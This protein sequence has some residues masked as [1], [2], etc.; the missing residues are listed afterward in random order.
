MSYTEVPIKSLK[1]ILVLQ[2]EIALRVI[3]MEL[4]NLLL[5]DLHNRHSGLTQS[6]AECFCEAAYVCLD[7][8]HTPPQDFILSGDNFEK[9]AMVDWVS[10]DERCKRA[11]SNKD[12]AT[13][14]GAYACALAATELCLGLYAVRRAETLTG[15]DYYIGSGPNSVEDLEDCL[16]LE[17]SGTDM[18]IYEVRRRLKIKVNQA[19]IGKSNLPAIAAVVGFKVKRILM[20]NVQGEQ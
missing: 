6:I 12:D 3:I 17:V 11:W 7:R 14:D 4:S 5:K 20:K 18:D 13:R 9:Q 8:N 1:Q 15:A 16:R 19:A 2:S 10:P